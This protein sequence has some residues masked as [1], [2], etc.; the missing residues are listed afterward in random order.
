[1]Q[2]ARYLA[3]MSEGRWFEAVQE[4][5]KILQYL[6]ARDGPNLAATLLKHMD[7]KRVSVVNWLRLQDKG[8]AG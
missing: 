8:G 4:H 6:V 7:A 5:E 2:R 1:M 3:N